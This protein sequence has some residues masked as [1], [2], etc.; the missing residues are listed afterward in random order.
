[1]IYFITGMMR[2]NLSVSIVG[3]VKSHPK[4]T[5]NDSKITIFSDVKNSSLNPPSAGFYCPETI[6]TEVQEDVCISTYLFTLKN[7]LLTL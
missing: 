6:N 1:M 2:I 5:I 3:M 4:V 7:L